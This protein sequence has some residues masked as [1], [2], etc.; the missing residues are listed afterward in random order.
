MK[1]KFIV[2]TGYTGC[3]HEVIEEVDDDMTEEELN[4]YATEILFEY[5]NV[6]Y[7]KLDE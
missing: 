2:E 5:V 3:N 6:S 1:V 7:R 4:Q